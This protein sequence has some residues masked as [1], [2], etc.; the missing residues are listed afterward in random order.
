MIYIFDFSFIEIAPPKIGRPRSL[1]PSKEALRKRL[2]RQKQPKEK[3]DL[4]RQKAKEG[5]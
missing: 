1:V 5:M 4:E 3:A 2:A